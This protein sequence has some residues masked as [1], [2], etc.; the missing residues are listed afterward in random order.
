MVSR[1]TASQV[2][3]LLSKQHRG[4]G[5]PISVDGDWGP[6]SERALK[7]FQRSFNPF[8][9][10]VDPTQVYG[11]G[12]AHLAVDGE[13]GPASIA[14]LQ[15]FR[16]QGNRLSLHFGFN[17]FACSKGN[18]RFCNGWLSVPHAV[19]TSAELLRERLFG[20]KV[21]GL[22][23]VGGSRCADHNRI[24]VKGA[25]NSQHL[26]SNNGNACDV[27]PFFTWQQ[28]RDSHSGV[29]AMETRAG[30]GALVYHIDCRPGDPNNP[31]IFGWTSRALIASDSGEEF[32]ELES[33][34]ECQL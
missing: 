8:R 28:I 31:Q 14:A 18:C 23:V 12:I 29:T 11:P 13:P 16:S 24:D 19:L 4:V 5:W 3:D 7:E 1:A 20:P 6:N 33:V 9:S 10:Q 22:E 2:Q 17:E 32:S 26:H 15:Y 30:T 25:S 27:R 34:G 21:G